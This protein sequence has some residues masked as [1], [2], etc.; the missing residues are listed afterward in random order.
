MSNRWTRAT[1]GELCTL[2][3]GAFPTE[4]TPPGAFPF[5]TTAERFRTAD[6]FQFDGEAVCIPT[7]SSTGH[8]HA[9]LKRVHYVRGKFAVA[10]LLM[11]AQ[12]RPGTPIDGRW[13]G[14]YLDHRRDELIVPLM[15]GTA[16]VNVRPGQLAGIEIH[17]PSLSEQRRIVDLVGSFDAVA[18]ASKR[19]ADAAGSLYRATLSSVFVAAAERVRLDDLAI[20]ARAGGTPDR[21]QPSYFGGSIPWLKSGEVDNPAIHAT[22]ESLSQ[23]GMDSSSAWVVPSG[24]VVIAMYGAT[25][26]AVGWT[27]VPLATNQ[28]VLSVVPNSDRIQPRLLF[29]LLRGEAASMKALAVGAAQ[30]NL[31]KRVLVGFPIALPPFDQQKRLTGL[32][33]ML[34]AASHQAERQCRAVTSARDAL[35]GDLLAGNGEIRP[36][37][38]RFLVGAA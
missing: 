10:N 14:L 36:S 33:D 35:V 5:V 22:E 20:T 26:G 15:Q 31:S 32:L 18:M 37:Y 21:K 28:A 9:S 29:H 23:A 25:A 16:N 12:P 6:D 27:E 2:T 38:D 34:L 11:A 3:R 1:L 7:I 4:R 19:L 24:T 30:P 13:L 17:L 8:G